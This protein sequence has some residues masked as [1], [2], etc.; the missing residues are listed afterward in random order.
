MN[1]HDY[2]VV[3]REA[4]WESENWGKLPELPYSNFELLHW[5]ICFNYQYV[6][7]SKTVLGKRKHTPFPCIYQSCQTGL[8]LSLQR[9][10]PGKVKNSLSSKKSTA[11]CF[12]FN[13]KSGRLPP[14]FAHKW[15]CPMVNLLNKW[16]EISSNRNVLISCWSQSCWRGKKYSL[17]VKGWQKFL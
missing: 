13:K 11:F 14:F 3:D 1:S 4:K 17:I 6:P 15:A 5:I 10:L 12:N 8:N 2:R 9:G 7:C 16:N